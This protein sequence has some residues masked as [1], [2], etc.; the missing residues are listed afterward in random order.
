MLD[1]QRGAQAETN[2]AFALPQLV[3]W[4][5]IAAVIEWLVGRTL[6]RG[7][8]FIP[9]TSP[10]LGLYQGLTLVGQFA[11][12][13]TG[14]LALVAAGWLAWR[15]RAELRGIFSLMLLAL[16]A[17]SVGFVF[18]AP[19][20]WARV[21]YH[22]LVLSA[23][24]PILRNLYAKSKDFPPRIPANLRE[25]GCE[26]IRVDSSRGVRAKIR[27]F[28][29]GF[30]LSELGMVAL[31]AHPIFRLSVWT[32]P[33]AAMIVGELY[34]LDG[35]LA[36]ALHAQTVTPLSS[37]LYNT[38][39]LLVVATPF[40]MWWMYARRTSGWMYA[41]AAIPALAFALAYWRSPALT[42][43]VA[44]WSLGLSLYL[45]WVLYAVSAWL[46]GVALLTF[47]RRDVNASPHLEWAVLLMIATGYAPPVS[48]HALLGLIALWLLTRADRENGFGFN[49][50]ANPAETTAAADRARDSFVARA[51]ATRQ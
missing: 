22:L 51:T 33:A 20:A 4:L 1:A 16:L 23:L 28:L 3:R 8:Y 10:V 29:I 2:A 24:V 32:L 45:P 48:T 9:K 12:T 46:M 34:L 30:S 18:V 31:R 15:M 6:T 11:F 7:A 21:G 17:A 43:I 42:G 38:G 27:G 37:A 41:T 39:E 5:A 49:A 44:M 19:S 40:A 14:V 13:L 35:A 50:R 47:W 36:N 26:K 25:S